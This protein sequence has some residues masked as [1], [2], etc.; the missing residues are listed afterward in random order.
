MNL[1]NGNTRSCG[2]ISSEASKRN[3]AIMRSHRS[4]DY[5]EGTDVRKLMQSPSAAN[6]SGIVGVSYDRSVHLWKATIQF[7]GKRYYLGS[8]VD[9]QVA[10]DIRREAEQRIHGDFLEWYYAEHPERRPD[11]MAKRKEGRKNDR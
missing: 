11:A 8:S 10:I 1:M 5:V 4:E 6:T 2:C 3:S 7:K 9:I